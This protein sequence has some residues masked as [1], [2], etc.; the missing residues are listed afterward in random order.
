MLNIEFLHQLKTKVDD[1]DTARS[2]VIK[3]ASDITKRSKRAIFE[4]HRDN[5]D[6]ALE[7]LKQA[8]SYINSILELTKTYPALRYQGAFTASIEEF[9]EARL[10]Y[11]FLVEAKFDELSDV[12]VSHKEYIGGLCDFS[13][14]IVRRARLLVINGHYDELQAN[15]DFLDRLLAEVLEYNLT[16]YLRTKFDQMKRNVRSM[17]QIL[18]D[19]SVKRNG[20]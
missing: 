2:E 4:L 20:I 1:Y 8:H 15:Y 9:V 17:E 13:G 16:S 3:V 12:S 11:T 10:F 5:Q 19:I 18:Y 6:K 14:E 7:Y